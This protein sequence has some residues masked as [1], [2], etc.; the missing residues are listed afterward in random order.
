MTPVEEY[1]HQDGRSVFIFPRAD[2]KLKPAQQELNLYRP[3]IHVQGI[4]Y[5]V[6]L[7]CFMGDS[8][9][10]HWPEIMVKVKKP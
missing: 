3:T 9:I 1:H 10:N 2:P 8:Q 6:T 5:H 4:T 7:V